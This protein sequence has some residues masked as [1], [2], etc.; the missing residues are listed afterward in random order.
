[1]FDAS[2]SFDENL[3]AFLS[4]C[5]IIDAECAKILS[6]SID[7]FVF[8]GS[9]RDARG[10]FNAKVKEAMEALPEKEVEA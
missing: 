9:D 8:H 10:S 7:I 6:D 1:M 4:E 3:A 2:K 5:N